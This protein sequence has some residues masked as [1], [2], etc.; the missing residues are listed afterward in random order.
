ME[1]VNRLY[2]KVAVDEDRRLARCVQPVAVND[3]MTGSGHQ[4]DI[5][6]ARGLQTGCYPFGCP[7]HIG[8]VGGQGRTTLGMRKK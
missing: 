6:C 1:G 4:L 8:F 5:L 7:L 3:R 2:I